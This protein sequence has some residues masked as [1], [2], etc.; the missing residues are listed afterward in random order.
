[1]DTTK[2]LAIYRMNS[3]SDFDKY[4]QESAK[5]EFFEFLDNA[6]RILKEMAPGEVL[7]IEYDVSPE[8]RERLIKVS[9]L[10]ILETNSDY[11]FSDD[12]T[13][14]KRL[15]QKPETRVQ[16]VILERLQK[17]RRIKNELERSQGADRQDAPRTK[18][19]I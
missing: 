17:K 13:V 19:T 1:M 5:A 12:Y 11:E 14:L 6:Y 2:N 10:F 7:R 4:L 15:E 18:R 3:L 9:C 16:E 8:N